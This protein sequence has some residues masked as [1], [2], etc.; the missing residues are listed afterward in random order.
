MS[1]RFTQHV[2]GTLNGR[3]VMAGE[4]F[5]LPDHVEREFVE[6]ELAEY[7]VE[8]QQPTETAAVAPTENAAARIS[9]PRPR[10]K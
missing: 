7:V 8:R 4:I 6:R 9:K 3:L 2:P 5:D 10:T 1:I